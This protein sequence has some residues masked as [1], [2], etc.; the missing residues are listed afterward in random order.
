MPDHY[1]CLS[2]PDECKQLCK[3]EPLCS[4][5]SYYPAEHP[6]Y[7]GKIV[8]CYLKSYKFF[9]AEYITNP[10]AVSGLKY[11]PGKRECQTV[12]QGY[13]ILLM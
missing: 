1:Y 10:N 8:N 9:N 3:D 6:G 4:A 11:C 5:W 12:N 13:G 2:T 7:G